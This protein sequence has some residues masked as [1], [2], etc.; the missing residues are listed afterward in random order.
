MSQK[1]KLAIVLNLQIVM[2]ENDCPIILLLLPF[3]E[4]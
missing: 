3:K 4:K 2:I 1:N